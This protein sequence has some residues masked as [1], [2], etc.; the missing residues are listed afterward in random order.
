MEQWRHLKQ[1]DERLPRLL[2]K[3]S[4]S[5]DGYIIRL[6]DLS[7]IWTEKLDKDNI[8]ARARRSNCSIDPSEDVEQYEIL[9]KKLQSALQQHGKTELTLSAT[10]DGNL[11][12]RLK[13][14]LPSSLPAFEWEVNLEQMSDCSVEVDLVS[15]LLARVH[16]LNYLMQGLIAEIKAKDRVIAKIT[17]RLET[18]GYGLADVFPGAAS[19]RMNGQRSQLEQFARHVRGLRKFDEEAWAADCAASGDCPPSRES[20]DAVF[21]SLPLVAAETPEKDRSMEWWQQLLRGRHNALSEAEPDEIETTRSIDVHAEHCL[22]ACRKSDAGVLDE[23]DDF[24]RQ[25]TPPQLRGHSQPS[26]TQEDVNMSEAADHQSQ[27][28]DS[29]EDEDDLDGPPP[30]PKE[31]PLHHPTPDN[32]TH[33]SINTISKTKTHSPQP[34][35]KTISHPLTKPCPFT[36]ESDTEEDDDDLEGQPSH[37][38]LSPSPSQLPFHQKSPTPQP[39]SPLTPPLRKRLGM[40]GRRARTKSP[41]PPKEQEKPAPPPPSQSPTRPWPKPKPKLGMIGGSK[42]KP[43]PTSPKITH[44]STDTHTS[45]PS[46]KIDTTGGKSSRPVT[47]SAIPEPKAA[48]LTEQE[49][50]E[51]EDPVERANAKR[52]ALKRE[53]EAKAKAPIKKKRKF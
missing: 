19:S 15:P 49:P 40:L 8:I 13:A 28:E 25:V 6:T 43:P 52:D 39:P 17:D 22:D 11:Q 34:I 20:A 32:N 21:D 38:P 31:K 45:L 42:T 5:K 35:A 3:A 53:L 4:F 29:T 10:E 30:K 7:R 50:V 36:H 46:K 48:D 1:S 16:N 51:P 12:L 23:E 2:I 33:H 24:Q 44:T 41:T 18:S 9:L 14:P 47:A 26:N 37:E 27:D